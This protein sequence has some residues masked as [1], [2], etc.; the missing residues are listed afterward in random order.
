MAGV[1]T[2]NVIE[3]EVIYQVR[4]GEVIPKSQKTVEQ[5]GRGL[6]KTTTELTK[7]DKTGKASTITTE[8]MNRG[9]QKFQMEQLGVMFAGM[10]LNRSM[11]NLNSTSR[12][13]L[14]IGDLM[15]TMMGVTML[16]SN[17]LLLENGVLPL[18]D[19]LTNLPEPAQKAIGLT[20][21][22]LEGL[23]ATMMVGGQLALGLSSTLTV[24]E[25]M[26]GAGGA[27]AGAAT[28]LKK[29]AGI[30]IVGVGVSLGI[31]SIMADDG[32]SILYALGSGLA[33]GLGVTLLGASAAT[34]ITLGALTVS[35]LIVWNMTSE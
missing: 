19:A 13:W 4:N 22:A 21:F 2:K 27:A 32:T 35:G 33:I 17:L 28:A 3:T 5:L 7:Y 25:K 12:E 18:F 30:S 26:G 1:Y 10:A 8:R 24:L 16:E 11:A 29:L 23:G 9:M 34:G 31:A 6:T 20:S 15:S 14:G